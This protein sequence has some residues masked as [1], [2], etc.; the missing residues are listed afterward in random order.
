M[1]TIQKEEELL[2]MLNRLD[3]EGKEAK[4][5]FDDRVKE[6]LGQ[7]SG[8]NQ[9]KMS[10]R[11][12]FFLYN[13]IG[14]NIETKVGKLSEAKPKIFILPQ[15]NGLG[16]VAD[17]IKSGVDFVWSEDSI[18]TK[19]ERAGFFGA[20]MGTA[21]VETRW[22]PHLRFGE[23][24]IELFLRDPRQVWID[25]SIKDVADVHKAEYVI[26]EDVEVLELAQAQYPGRGAMLIPSARHS[27]MQDA[28]KTASGMVRTALEN[29]RKR[30]GSQ[31]RGMA[32]PRTV[33]RKYWFTDRRR[34]RNDKGRFPILDGLTEVAPNGGVPFPG[35]RRIVTGMTEA[36]PIVL[37][38]TYNKY[39]DGMWPHDLLA[40]NIDLETIWGPDD[41][42]RQVKIQ[43][44]INRL[45]DAIVGNA[46]KNSIIRYIVDRGAMDPTELKKFAD[47]AA[48]V[49]YKNPGRQVEQKIPP[50]LPVEIMQ[51][52]HQFIDMSK[53]NI[54]VLDPQIQKKMPSI[55][56]GPAIEGLQLAVEGAIRTVARRME[57]FISRFGQK[58]V[59]RIFQ[60]YTS[61]RLLHFVGESG[62]WREFEF[63]R[64]KLLIMPDK[65]TGQLRPRKIDELQTAYRDFRFAVEPG[66]SLAVTKLQRM[67]LKMDAFKAGGMRLTK[68]M[69][70]LG[71]ENPEEEI[72]K[73]AIEREKYG[74]GQEDGGDGR[75][76]SKSLGS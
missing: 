2:R 62:E 29:L 41:V 34:T 32:I 57:E 5:G 17:V 19:L 12:P 73:A 45:G 9:W 36:G 47:D 18:T 51:L 23:G 60:Y 33:L 20:E 46:L 13:V 55:V 11:K 54:G 26:T 38:D 68:V 63:E 39:W 48:E 67:Q 8:K 52:I 3:S 37:E 76:K 22:N 4:K 50:T 35:G 75:K 10:G 16:G 53:R 65:A 21:T 58:I 74:L 6:N 56:T 30:G 66:S 42:A 43:E 25:P 14:E 24:E 71:V 1:A 44:A 70:E 64:S 7:V 61:D 69:E 40:W 31:G 59:S 27:V 28:D 72:E 15:R 49:I